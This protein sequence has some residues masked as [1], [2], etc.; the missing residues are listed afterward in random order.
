LTV[1]CERPKGEAA[2]DELTFG[3]EPSKGTVSDQRIGSY[4][5]LEPL[6]SG[7]MSSVFRAVH[8]ETGHEV[9][10]KVLTRTLARNSTLL[11][12]FMREARSAEKLEHQN[13][14][15]IYDRGIDRGRHYLALEYVA[16]GD[17]HEYVQRQGP[18]EAIEAVAIVSSVASGLRYAA[19]RGLIHRDIKPS[20]ILRL[21]SGK[22]KIIDLG[23]ALQNEFEDER[24]TRE[25]T[26]VGTV[27]YMAP[28]Q[29]RDSRAT[30]IQSDIYSLGCT[31][32]YLLTGVAAYPGGDITDKLTR[33]A[34]S[35]IPD[36]RDL[37]PEVPVVV[38][39]V[40]Q[41]MMAKK[42]EDRY[43][44]Y[45]DLI[46]S[47][48]AA[49]GDRADQ[50]GG[51]ALVP[52]AEESSDDPPALALDS[53]DERES[54][55]YVAK[56]G[57]SDLSPLRELSMAELALE[58]SDEIRERPATRSL[59]QPPTILRRAVE[60]SDARDDE[61]SSIDELAPMPTPGPAA[62][63]ASV[64]IIAGA[65]TG[66]A[67]FLLLLG[68]V[69]ISDSG[70]PATND[71]ATHGERAP[72]VD[73]TDSIAAGPQL[74]VV[75]NS[76]RPTS[77]EVRDLRKDSKA[78]PRETIA[79]WVEPV[80]TEPT[81]DAAMATRLAL[82]RSRL[83]PEWA[84][85]AVPDR[86]E[87]PF[88]V[89]RRVVDSSEVATVPTLYMALDQRIGGTVEFADEGPFF[90]DD[91]RVAGDSRLI[92]ARPGYRP[93][94][95]VERSSSQAVRKQPAVFVLA[96]QN[97]I[98]DGIDLIVDVRDIFPE[99]TAL[100]S[101][102]GSNLTLRNCT[103]TILN[104]NNTPFSIVRVE[105]G[106]TRPTRI[107]LERTFIRGGFGAAV[108]LAQ[109][110]AELALDSTMIVGGPGP[111]VRL[112]GAPAPADTR[113]FFVDSILAGPGPT[114]E[115]SR[116]EQKSPSKP[117]A[118]R[119]FGSIFARIHGA[120]V[121]SVIA[122][123]GSTEAAA[124]QIE[125]KGDRNLFAGWKGFF[126]C[127]N[128]PTIT[129]PGLAEVRSTWNGADQD[130]QEIPSPWPP[131]PSDLA[132]VTRGELEPFVPNREKIL[133][134]VAQ[135]RA[136]LFEKAVGEYTS[137][138]IPQLA[139]WAFE[140]PAP[141]Q[142]FLRSAQARPIA[143][144]EPSSTGLRKETP[145]RSG[146]NN[147]LTDPSELTFDTSD[148]TWGGD[149]GVF[150]RDRLT[151]GVGHVRVRV[152]GSGHHQFTPVRLA[153]GLW[154]EI[155]VEPLSAAEPPSWSPA[156]NST[157]PALIQSLGGALFISHFNL[158][159]N[160]TSRL[161]HLIHVEDGDLV[162]S[163]C[164]ITAPGSTA[165]FAGDLIAFRSLSTQPYSTDPGR[166]IFST[167]VNRPVCRL[168][169]SVL[170]TSGIALRAELGRGLVALTECAIAGGETGVELVPSRVSSRRFDVDLVMDHCT[171]TAEQPVVRLGPWL[172]S[173]KGPDRPWLITS[174]N[175][176]FLAMYERKTRETV[177]LRADAD[178]LARG[179]V[180]WQ[181]TDDAVDVDYFTAVGTGLPSPNRPR[182]L[183]LQWVHFWGYRHMNGRITGPRGTGSQP[184]VRFFDRLR[185]GRVEPVDLLLNR[186]YH[187]DRDT[188]NVGADLGW[189]GL[190][191]RVNRSGRQRN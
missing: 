93:I 190:T 73:Q 72:T 169:E 79:K 45:D 120:G 77:R 17:F 88:V 29:A 186:D 75:T 166:E 37:R 148:P 189:L 69:Q 98:L 43:A 11:Q 105:P 54:G 61:A 183:H 63:R 119:A 158:R 146:A 184:S 165:D 9:A 152:I 145:P 36:V 67:L 131:F 15:T 8:E 191:P 66:V 14:V 180:S 52:L 144:V 108:D 160:E 95:R 21:P 113:F 39:A 107:R 6:G 50:G 164:Q 82:A 143:P 140:P 104:H 65:F 35:P 118:V 112:R 55:E 49:R 134:Q 22:V 60:N 19:S 182:D 48:D 114:I 142:A 171:L 91:F 40:I 84:N 27:D 62:S 90:N 33:H 176:A 115:L 25:G 157:G 78:S 31:F 133:S 185:P 116:D 53:W 154:L 150:L 46:A 28:E 167:R 20:N 175:C 130:S 23:L 51:I 47:L 99:Q 10:L 111:A 179:T 96:R 159:H 151:P 138:V 1:F 13:I 124:K 85:S 177:L 117:L 58:Q 173:L 38:S 41:K 125:W 135:P 59:V 68:L 24:V 7:G 178:A 3:N 34:R 70:A 136:G 42:P 92:R 149:L 4:R 128:D 103:I 129:V 102:T 12:R 188:L 162:M 97:L 123:T 89:V 32:Y 121:A 76:R 64:W 106:G 155:R 137:P 16:G 127:G 30:S 163:R 132:A 81:E 172:G 80:D 161:E 181:A 87:G 109:S 139:G 168:H 101:C 170:I 2:M 141:S 187:P 156:P 56:A 126:A 44:S 122:S 174:R 71:V 110:A 83:L 18:L 100:F 57:D 153:A 86:I 5:V 74:A 94:V 147:Q 26:T